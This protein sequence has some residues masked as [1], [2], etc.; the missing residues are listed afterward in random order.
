MDRM[1]GGSK[2]RWRETFLVQV[3]ET[4]ATYFSSAAANVKLLKLLALRANIL[5]VHIW[6]VELAE[7][8]KD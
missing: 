6:H 1:V 5:A 4:G 3:N 8:A 7:I 2:P